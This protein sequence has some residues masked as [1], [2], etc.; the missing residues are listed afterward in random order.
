VLPRPRIS[1]VSPFLD[2]QHGTELCVA[3]QIERLSAT[4]DIHLYS[5]RVS[6]VDLSGITWHRVWVPP[7]PHLLRFVWWFFANHFY[8]WQD[9]RLRR[10]NPELVYS[11]GVNCV[12]ADLIGVH[13]VFAKMRRELAGELRLMRN[14]R[15][16]W[17]VILHR[18]AYY[19]LIDRLEHL[20]Y[21]RSRVALAA[22]SRLVA[23]DIG[24]F[25]GRK[26]NVSVIY[27]GIDT[28]KFSVCRRQEL[29]PA[30]R[31]ALGLSENTFAVLLIGNDW[32]KKG[33][34]CLL[35]AAGQ[36][37]NPQLRILVAGTDSQ[38]P[39]QSPISRL[40]LAQQVTFLPIRKDVEFYYAA[41]DAYVGPSLEDAFSLPPA[42][43]MACGLPVVTTRLAGVSEIIHH[44][45]DGLILENPGDA[46]LLAQWLGRLMT[47]RDWHKSLGDAAA[48]T[49]KQ[50]T[51]ARN[52]EQL[53]ELFEQVRQRGNSQ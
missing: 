31:T 29:R 41:A 19:L 44:G 39:Y 13:I 2:K 12:D 50:Y 48:Q 3:E 4:Y 49:A 23:H 27:H 20:L 36:L 5:E 47:D 42:E 6:G 15:R 25:H 40:G 11:P 30:A 32:K 37:H 18:R 34:S 1:V 53:R 22:V 45:I 26:N 21:G 24:E 43:A 51:W 7:G 46:G 10:L 28:A 9:R 17:P 38:T 52:A 33:L 8:R 35:E 16:A 14:P